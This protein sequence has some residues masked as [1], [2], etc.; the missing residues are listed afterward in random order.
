[1]WK[2][3]IKYVDGQSIAL[4][5]RSLVELFNLL[6]SGKSGLSWAS[7]SGHRINTMS[8]ENGVKT[9]NIRSNQTHNR[10][11]MLA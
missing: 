3:T 11:G 10:E 8:L 6:P 4:E 5:G 2:L 1:M 9:G 7:F